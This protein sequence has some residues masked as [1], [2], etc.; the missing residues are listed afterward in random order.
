MRA[1]EWDWF[2]AGVPADNVTVEDDIDT[3]D[4]KC[5]QISWSDSQVNIQDTLLKDRKRRLVSIQPMRVQI[6]GLPGRCRVIV[7]ITVK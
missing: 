5:I 3:E 4:T 2:G 1:G 6:A 7:I